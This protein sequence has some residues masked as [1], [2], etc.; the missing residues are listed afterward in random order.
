MTGSAGPHP[1]LC[2][3]CEEPVFCADIIKIC[4]RRRIE[5]WGATNRLPAAVA[6]HREWLS[7]SVNHLVQQDI[8]IVDES[9][10][11]LAD[12]LAEAGMPVRRQADPWHAR[13]SH[14]HRIPSRDPVLPHLASQPT[15]W[16]RLF[17]RGY[18]QSAAHD[19]PCK[20]NSNRNAIGGPRG[21]RQAASMARQH[22]SH[23]HGRAH[24]PSRCSS[25]AGV[26]VRSWGSC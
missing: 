13:R 5:G 16:L 7:R 21:R 2:L 23:A 26:C 4:D 8:W 11:G 25:A 12:L 3:H 15:G 1:G 10:L 19:P 24:I 20:A 9:E 6:D 14:T 17:H 22:P 18:G